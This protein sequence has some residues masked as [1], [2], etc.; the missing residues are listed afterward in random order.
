M[1]IKIAHE[2]I[3]RRLLILSLPN[4]GTHVASHHRG[5]SLIVIDARYHGLV[6]IGHV[7]RHIL[8]DL[9]AFLPAKLQEQLM[10]NFLRVIG[11]DHLC[12]HLDDVLGEHSQLAHRRTLG[13]RPR[14]LHERFRV[15]HLLADS[16][17]ELVNLLDYLLYNLTHLYFRCRLSS[18]K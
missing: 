9:L 10:E 7:H 18:T 5:L 2:G 3:I 6:K 4:V 16:L 15:F 17:L 8:M 11:V 14:L 1:S 12:H 13:C